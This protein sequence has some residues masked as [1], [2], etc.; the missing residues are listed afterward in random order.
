MQIGKPKGFGRAGNIEQ[1][2]MGADDKE[3]VN[4]ATSL[5]IG[6]LSVF[7]K[8]HFRT[9]PF[10]PQYAQFVGYFAGKKCAMSESAPNMSVQGATFDY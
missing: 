4:E 9:L 1:Q 8:D 6:G 3:R 2:S 7:R 5:V 10:D